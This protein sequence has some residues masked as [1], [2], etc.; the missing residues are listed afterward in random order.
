MQTS[1][2]AS[3]ESGGKDGT[4][5]VAIQMDVVRPESLGMSERSRSRDGDVSGRGCARENRQR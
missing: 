5:A 3:A 4:S 1:V 2:S